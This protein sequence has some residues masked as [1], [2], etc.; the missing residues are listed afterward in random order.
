M[1]LEF[2]LHRDDIPEGVKEEI[3]LAIDD[4]KKTNANFLKAKTRLGFLMKFS[5][6]ISF[7]VNLTGI[8]RQPL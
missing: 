5:P 8:S 6:A 7:H 1:T 4:H 2:L 3:Q